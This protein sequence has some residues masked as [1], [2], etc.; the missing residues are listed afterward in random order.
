MGYFCINRWF[1]NINYNN[2]IR[3][4]LVLLKLTVVI[5]S[6]VTRVSSV[7]CIGSQ[8]ISCDDSEETT[9]SAG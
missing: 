5:L 6:L 7:I 2:L 1:T 4:S 3:M 8:C 9:Y